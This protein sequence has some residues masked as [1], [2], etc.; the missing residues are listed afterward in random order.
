MLSIVT[1]ALKEADNPRDTV[2]SLDQLRSL[3]AVST[4][5]LAA[6]LLFAFLYLAP[7][8]LASSSAVTILAAFA[9]KTVA[10]Q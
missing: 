7:F 4:P 10:Q 2:F 8:G 3:S 9:S 5:S 6:L 1:K